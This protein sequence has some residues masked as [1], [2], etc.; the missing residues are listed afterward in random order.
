M[1]LLD[2]LYVTCSDKRNILNKKVTAFVY[3]HARFLYPLLRALVQNTF[4]D[5]KFNDV[6]EIGINMFTIKMYAHDFLK[7]RSTL[8]RTVLRPL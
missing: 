3:F 8:D 2:S 1:L 5:I 4:E 7:E 6:L